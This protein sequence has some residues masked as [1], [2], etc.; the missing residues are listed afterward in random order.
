MKLPKIKINPV[1][2]IETAPS[3]IFILLVQSGMDMRAAGWVGCG[4]AAAATLGLVFTRQPLH[5]IALG[6]N[7]YMMLAIPIILVTI[8]LAGRDSADF[9]I[10]NAETGVLVV[11][12]LIGLAMTLFTHKG[13]LNE[14]GV[15]RDHSSR[16]SLLL[17]ISVLGLIAFSIQM[18]HNSFLA[19][20]APL[21][22]LFLLRDYLARQAPR[23]GRAESET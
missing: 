7:I 12:F 5:P 16:F 19:I 20:G 3:L 9:M 21:I 23:E 11:L 14:P 10:R 1:R 15:H 4:L 2:I 6:L 22:I 18:Q 17:L 13:F 8:S